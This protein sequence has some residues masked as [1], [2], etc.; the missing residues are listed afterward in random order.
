MPVQGLAHPESVGMSC[1]RLTEHTENFAL[2]HSQPQDGHTVKST[3]HPFVLAFPRRE[4]T[5][6]P[7][8]AGRSTGG[9]RSS[10]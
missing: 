3:D 4:P 2:G 1:L 9:S 7:P 5:I 8:A 10:R 6:A